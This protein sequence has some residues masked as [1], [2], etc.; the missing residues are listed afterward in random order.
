MA[1][2][3]RIATT[4]YYDREAE[5]FAAHYDSVTFEAVHPRLLQYLPTMGRALDVGAGSGRD[6]AGLAAHGLDVTAV[7]PSSGLR[8]IGERRSEPIQWIDDRLPAISRLADWSGCYDI[9]LCSA[10]LMLVDHDE[11]LPSFATMARLLTPDGRIAVNIRE[12]MPGEPADL[13][14]SHSDADILAAAETV[15]LFCIDR[16]EVR[17]ALGRDAYSWRSFIFER[18][19]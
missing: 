19:G 5:S 8:A 7:E 4:D 11:L 10:V 1:L 18:T 12:P 6:A 16:A 17:D 9:I 14:F 13:F 2:S 3:N 15:G